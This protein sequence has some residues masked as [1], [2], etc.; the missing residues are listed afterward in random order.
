M[1]IGPN[2]T[3]RSDGRFEA[4][5]EK[6][7]NPDG[8]I[9][10]G[11]CYGKTA[12]TAEWKRQDAMLLLK[13]SHSSNATFSILL[14]NF[15]NNDKAN[16]TL[17][18]RLSQPALG[19]LQDKPLK[20]IKSQDV[21]DL[22]V[23]YKENH[24]NKEVVALYDDF[25]TV[26]A[27]AVNE[28]LI[29]QSPIEHSGLLKTYIKKL[30]CKGRKPSAIDSSDYL[31]IEQSKLLL[32]SINTKPNERKLG[33]LLSLTMGLR[34]S[35]IIVL[36]C[37]DIDADRN[38]LTVNKEY[39]G[40]I[41]EVACTERI[42]PM[43]E[44]AVTYFKNIQHLY[45][46]D[47]E[48][49]VKR[50]ARFGKVTLLENELASVNS[51][52][53]QELGV[54]SEILR[55]TFAVN[56]LENGTSLIDLAEYMNEPLADMWT[57][58]GSFIKTNFNSVVNYDRENISQNKG[59][60]NLLILG[61]GDYGHTVKEIAERIG[62]FD[63]IAF[64]DDDR[65]KAEAIDFCT[66]YASYRNEFNA[67]FPAFGDNLLRNAYLEK[68]ISAGFI[69]PKLI[70]PSATVSSGCKIDNG[71][72]V[73][74]NAT[75]NTGAVIEMGSLICSSALVDRGAVISRCSH[76]DCAA[77]VSKDSFVKPFSHIEYG[78]AYA[79]GE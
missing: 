19:C 58:F 16:E 14:K 11:F 30:K 41:G 17:C 35:E 7:R 47:G 56:K 5:Y 57:R 37:R 59:K 31:T 42:L 69:I 3:K 46:N 40:R 49:V 33:L 66:N 29:A 67:A 48:H 71:V 53:K 43:P 61:A 2:I 23:S 44:I 74:A 8:T 50:G 72:I 10:L 39:A 32:A 6:G 78:K 21:Y 77:I 22:L 79:V 26:F 65:A 12:E 76:I 24:K 1:N 13:N 68:L 73:E 9:I 55:N 38:L 75:V 27:Y 25:E 51:E 62:I 45:K 28:G 63:R 54:D 52:C 70:H 60:F 64:L 34:F 18:K 20:D 36:R 4:R 15:L